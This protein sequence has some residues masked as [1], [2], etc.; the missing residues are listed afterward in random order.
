MGREMGA[1]SQIVFDDVGVTPAGSQAPIVSAVNLSL[2]ERRIAI[3]GGNGS[4]KSTL[5]RMI[6]GLVTATTGRVGVNGLNPA[7]DGAAVRKTV[8][9]IFTQPHAQLVM[10][11]VIEDISLSLRKTIRNRQ[12]RSDH[13]MEI[14]RAY[15]LDA[16]AHTSVHA[17]SGGQQQLLAL[18]GVL[19]VGPQIIVADEPTTL[20]DLRNSQKIAT[21]LLSLDQQLVLVTHDLGLAA[22]CERVIVMDQGS[23]CFDGAAEAAIAYY[24]DSVMSP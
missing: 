3:I 11:T 2:R 17:L 18:A 24:R 12:R 13:A 9:F 8:G 16:H 22:Q 5:A 19:A 10:P 6:N 21:A 7:R 20:L 4:G 15:G 1:V 23:V 14:L